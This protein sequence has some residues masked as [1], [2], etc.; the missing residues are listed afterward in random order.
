MGDVKQRLGRMVWSLLFSAV[1]C[2]VSG[3]AFGQLTSCA[4][5]SVCYYVA[6]QPIDVCS[7]T[8]TGCAAFNNPQ[9][10]NTCPVGNP[11]AISSS[12]PIGFFDPSTGKDLTRQIWNKLG[13]DISYSAMKKW[14]NGNYQSVTL[15]TDTSSTQFTQMTTAGFPSG[16]G[17]APPLNSDA[18]VLNMFFINNLVPATS[19][20][21]YGFS[22]IGNNGIAISQQAFCPP[23]PVT[24]R[25]DT[26]AHELGHNLGLN[27]LDVFNYGFGTRIIAQAPA[28]DLM[29]QGSDR[30]VPSSTSN[31]LSQLSS[32]EG[33]GTADQMD[34]NGSKTTCAL[35]TNQASV[36]RGEVATSGFL[37]PI[38]NVTTI[39][40]ATNP[41]TAAAAGGPGPSPFDNINQGCNLTFTVSHPDTSGWAFE[42]ATQF[43]YTPAPGSQF[44]S[45]TFKPVNQN[46]TA[47]RFA[48]SL[49]NGTLV[50]TMQG[51]PHQFPAYNTST[52]VSIAGSSFQFQIGLAS[53]TGPG[54]G[55]V[56]GMHMGGSFIDG[57]TTF[58]TFANG[59]AATTIPDTTMPAQTDPVAYAAFTKKVANRQKACS[60]MVDATQPGLTIDPST[61]CPVYV[62]AD[63]DPTKNDGQLS[64]PTAVKSC[65]PSGSLAALLQ[66]PNVTAYVANGAWGLGYTGVQVVPIEPAGGTPA[67]ISTPNP[68]NSCASNSIS[69]QTVCVANNTDVYL[70]SQTSP[71]PT[72]ATLTSGAS[73][74][75]G[76]TGGSCANCGVAI[77]GVG[78][79][80]VITM[81]LNTGPSGTG[82][83][84]LNLANNTFSTPLA[85]ANHVS[86]SVQWDPIRNLILSPNENGVYDLF[87][88]SS[89]N[90][91]PEYANSVSSLPGGTT[92]L[93]SAAED[94]T[95]GIALAGNEFQGSL[96]IANLAHAAYI[97][98][99][100]GTWTAPQQFS[101]FPE[102]NFVQYDG[103]VVGPTGVAVAP[104]SQYAVVAG[105]F[106]G[107]GFGVV[108]LP[109]SAP[110]GSTPPS[111]VNYVAASLPNT[112]DGKVWTHGLDPHTVTAYISPNDSKAY[113]LLADLPS[114]AFSCSESTCIQVDSPPTYLAVID[115]AA[116]LTA[117]RTGA[118]SHT[119]SPSYDLIGNGVVRY[120]ATR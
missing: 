89:P 68:V 11:T 39:G 118:G 37:N 105:E 52:G 97:P 74:N 42:Y 88:T 16:T 35:V 108:Q 73:A 106:G 71:S 8:G 26:L 81:G 38:Q 10:N 43:T 95:T 56:D 44:I 6:I 21:L 69:G 102:F 90:T 47:V 94:C 100:P 78:N 13:V 62:I 60:T 59:M 29:T 31:A 4:A 50:L 48:G 107:N 111:V 87:D 77:N 75:T 114:H 101:S 67:S 55:S 3:S 53:A 27:H 41:T 49:V 109:A 36:Q 9:F 117:P 46:A 104:G 91:A 58:S 120:I 119:V 70:L 40:T 1:A 28:A 115:M 51:P 65:T 66:K 83:Q 34:C 12:N 85:A 57:F 24:P 7:S 23:Y 84:F 25:Y 30:T 14:N 76:F 96:Y 98:G 63:G 2:L 110:T 61:G 54:C 99:P 92:L 33:T 20:T 18:H 72:D 82:I 17:T 86:E 22:W 103:S 45:G 19:G 32:G 15:Q 93:D 112:P 64:G 79:L 113:A 5:G 116:L 80:A